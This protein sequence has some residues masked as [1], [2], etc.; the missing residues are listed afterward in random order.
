MKPFI[1]LRLMEHHKDTEM[2]DELI[3]AVLRNKG[4]ADEV[5]LSSEYG[6]PPLSAHLESAK[7]MASAATR[8]RKAGIGCSLQISN[9]LGHGDYLKALDFSGITWQH[10]VG[11]DGTV[12]G[13]ANCPND[14]QFHMYLKDSTRAYAAWQPDCLWIDD[15]LR[16]YSHTPVQYGCFCERCIG[17]FASEQGIRFTR[18]QLVKAINDPFDSTWR[19]KWVAF[20]RKSLATVARIIMEAAV[21]AA[22]NIKGGLQQAGFDWSNY[23]GTDLKPVYDALYQATGKPPLSRPG[24]GFYTDHAPRQ[25]LDKALSVSLQNIRLPDYVTNTRP[26]VENFTHSALGKSSHGTV[27]ES[28]LYLAY[29][30]NALSYAILMCDNERT[31]WHEKMLCRIAQ[32]RPYWEQMVNLNEDT[33]PGGLGIAFSRHHY[34]RK[35]AA[36]ENDFSWAMPRFGNVYQMSLAG[37]PLCWDGQNAP[38]VLLYPD[39]VDGFTADELKA[40][41]AKGVITD[42]VALAKLNAR[43]LCGLTGVETTP[44]TGPYYCERMTEDELNAGYEG[45][46]WIQFAMSSQQPV[47]S[48]TSTNSDTRVLGQYAG[49]DGAIYGAATLV[50]ETPCGGRLAVFGYNLWENVVNSARRNQLLRAADYVSGGNLPA[51]I[52]TVSQVATIPRVDR[53]GFTRSVTLLNAS[54]DQSE[55]LTL[56]VRNTIGK[57]T[58]YLQPCKADMPLN[59]ETCASELLVTVPAMEPWSIGTLLFQ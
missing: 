30:C 19:S 59:T 41:L 8:L 2:L 38:A 3:Q 51:F 12:S 29:G 52:E 15:D 54:I 45:R 9:C 46:R 7:C 28:S 31:S 57:K 42:G 1:S 22:P 40:M 44:V 49:A 26:E 36:G 6:F 58:V 17:L 37:L 56:R 47:Y 34:E 16:M 48:L 53:Q 18:E 11:H 20:N 39:A 32:W 50:T 55:A 13:Y 10:M 33:Q 35:M 4:C 24:G 27:V 14:P 23:S 21:E 43:G 5:W 25:M